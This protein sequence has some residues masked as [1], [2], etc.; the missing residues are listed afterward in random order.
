M[1]SRAADWLFDAVP[2]ADD[3]FTLPANISSSSLWNSV[4]FPD[5]FPLD[6]LPQLPLQP[7]TQHPPAAP[8]A[9]ADNVSDVTDAQMSA[10]PPKPAATPRD[11][12]T[13]QYS[14]RKQ[15]SRAQPGSGFMPA[16]R[17][18]AGRGLSEAPP[19][20][21]P[22]K[23]TR[24]RRRTSCEES[25]RQ[26]HNAMMRENR[27]RFN[28]KFREIST[29]LELLAAPAGKENA[30]PMKNKIQILERAMLQYAGME[31]ERAKCKSELLFADDGRDIG[32]EREVLAAAAGPKEACQV[33]VRALCAGRN[34]KYGEV[35][36]EARDGGD[37]FVLEAAYVSPRNMPATR[38]KL[39]VHARSLR[40]AGTSTSCAAFLRQVE[41]LRHAVWVA[42]A[43]QRQDGGER[44][45][46][47]VSTL[48]AMPVLAGQDVAVVV[49]M[50][51][52][53]E[54]LAFPGGVRPYERES[55]RRVTELA[56]A[57]QENCV[58]G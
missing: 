31:S 27:G 9:A 17:L 3:L 22:L 58:K 8:V 25:S 48:M 24:V 23:E 12:G 40:S 10:S 43:G 35:W 1:D 42:D 33:I 14:P 5:A 38:S 53:D 11:N 20:G 56:K 44:A 37:G 45:A 54:L 28:L 19:Q 18:G 46:A 36:T 32:I 26:K 52:D 4:P 6:P 29:L 30:K 41:R 7:H 13:T 47:G 49:V 16:L 51:A 34:W 15:T 50:H 21:K 2:P 57:V 55:L 39:E